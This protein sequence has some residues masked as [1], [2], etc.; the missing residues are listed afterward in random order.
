ML[1]VLLVSIFL[2]ALYRIDVCVKGFH[3]DFLSKEKTDSIRG[4]FILLIVLKHSLPYI[5]RAAYA[6]E[7]YGDIAVDVF[8]GYMSQLV[9]VM[10]LIYSGYGVGE[11]YKHKGENYV[12][13]MPRHRILSTF[14]NFDVAVI[15][16]ILL[17]IVLG[18]ELSFKQA[19]LS[20]TGWESV[21]N[22][23][24]YIFVILM[25][26]SFTYLS[27]RWSLPNRGCQV[28]IVFVLCFFAIM[29]LSQFKK[30]CWYNTI[31]CYPLG[32]LF[33]AFKKQFV[34]CFKNYYWIVAA[35]LL[36]FLALLHWCPT[37]LFCLSYNAYGM[38]FGLLV[39]LLTMKVGISNGLLQWAGKKLFPIYI[40]MHM[41]MLAM[42]A[43]WPSL[44]DTQP[45][46]FVIISLII[47]LVIAFF[48]R[49]WQIKLN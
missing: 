25:C 16:Y 30:T 48:Y 22:S 33:S 1:L 40:Y 42:E 44:I 28:A 21:G 7:G 31:L 8:F 36:L 15:L 45:A 35:V 4:I 24:W 2:L 19:A 27:L 20:L 13:Q 26:Y 5:K 29:F 49:F 11:S 43:K 23:N 37:D 10:F 34:K 3:D 14:L 46:L 12:K 39:M 41:P 18:H 32:F 38:V 47:T 9:V 6:Y 17:V